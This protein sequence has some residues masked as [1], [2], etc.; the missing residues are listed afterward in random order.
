MVS[1][2]KNFISFVALGGQNPQILNVDFLKDEKIIPIDE[3]PF[4]QI[5]SQ[6]KPVKKFISLPGLANLVIGNLEIVIDEGRFQ[7]RE[8]EISEWVDTKII[9]IAKRY[10]EVLKYTPLKLIGFNF[11]STIV[12]DTPEEAE[13]CQQIC[14]PK[15]SPLVKIIS[16][17]NINISAS[18]VLRYPYGDDGGRILLTIEQPNKE[19][20]RRII[21]FNYEF[22]FTDWTN[23]KRELDKYTEIANYSDS[24]LEGLVK[25]L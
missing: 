1:Q 18:S 17:G 10:F 7:I 4:D 12:F 19:N 20:T 22:N 21:N 9:D 15:G 25:L 5:F 13:N 14:L 2:S 8:T 11:N 24:I 6:E 3:A 16:R 23:F